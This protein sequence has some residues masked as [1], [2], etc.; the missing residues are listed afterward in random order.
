MARRLEKV[1]GSGEVRAMGRGSGGLGA[2]ALGRSTMVG[3]LRG[4][5]DQG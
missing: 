3:G 2:R 4:P 5:D 1:V